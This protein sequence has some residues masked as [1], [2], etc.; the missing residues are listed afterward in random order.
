MFRASNEIRSA[1]PDELPHAVA[2]IV[3]AFITDPIARFAWPS[4]HGHLRAMPLAAREFA[5]GSFEHGTAYVTTDFCGTALWLP[6]GVHPNGEALEGVF[7]RTAR[8]EHLDDLLATLTRFTAEAI[9]RSYREHLPAF[10]DEVFI[11]GGGAHNLTLLSHLRALCAPVPVNDT[12]VLGVDAK[13]K[14]A[15][16]FAV[17]ANESLFGHPGNVPSAT[18]ARGP[19]V[20]GK[21]TF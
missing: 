5:G 20:L 15:V 1:V 10:P 8:P 13:A 18:G 7:R 14:E 2:A 9:A 17:L 21:F 19:R 6:P 12:G 11:S 3:A 16:A 4:P